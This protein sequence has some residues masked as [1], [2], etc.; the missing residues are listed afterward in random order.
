MNGYNIKSSAFRV[1][2]I[3]ETVYIGDIPSSN[4]QTGSLFFFTVPNVGSQNPTI[5]RLM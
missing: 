2:G 4:R 3:A 1:F 5:V